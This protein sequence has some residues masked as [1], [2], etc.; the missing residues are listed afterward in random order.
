MLAPIS[1]EALH[2]CQAPEVE[3]ALRGA[4]ARSKRL[5]L[6]PEGGGVR[7]SLEILECSRAERQEGK[8]TSKGGPGGPV[9]GPGQGG[10]ARV[11]EGEIGVQTESIRLV[12]LRARIVSGDRFIDVVSGPKDRTLAEAA[13]S[14][15]RALDDGLKTRGAWLVAADIPAANRL[16]GT[17]ELVE[18]SPVNLQDSIPVGVPNRKEHYAADGKVFVLRPD[19]K[20]GSTT[21]AGTYT[22]DGTKRRLVTPDGKTVETPVVFLSPDRMKLVHGPSDEWTY[23]RLTGPAAYDREL[24]PRSVELVKSDSGTTEPMPAY[25]TGDYSSLPLEQRLKGVWELA[26][27]KDVPRADLPPYGFTNDVWVDTGTRMICVVR[28]GSSLS[29]GR[30]AP[31]ALKDG[32]LELTGEAP[33]SGTYAVSFDRWQR[34]VLKGTGTAGTR[35][36]KLLSRDTSVIPR[37]PVRIVLLEP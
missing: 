18:V 30:C 27:V 29:V 36:F 16:V 3:K 11:T 1:G 37:L 17:W 33:H 13:G 28:P 8:F 5:R 22:F 6:L 21:P 15:R 24:E 20:L 31:A 34:L 12:A 19:E 26:S 35:T 9:R 2:G 14:L 25:D 7:A 23:S 4:L 32:S 10:V